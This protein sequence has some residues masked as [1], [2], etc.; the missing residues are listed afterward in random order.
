[1]PVNTSAGLP[2]AV[3][4]LTVPLALAAPHAVDSARSW[5]NDVAK[6]TG[7]LPRYPVPAP[8]LKFTPVCG[9]T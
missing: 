6:S 4:L 9:V 7:L 2:P 1:M 8:P 3:P 5:V